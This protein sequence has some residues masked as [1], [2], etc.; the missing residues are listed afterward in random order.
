MEYIMSVFQFEDY[1]NVEYDDFCKGLIRGFNLCASLTKGPHPIIKKNL[2]T[3]PSFLIPKDVKD[4]FSIDN[5]KGFSSIDI[6]GAQP[7]DLS[8]INVKIGCYRLYQS[9]LTI[10]VDGKYVSKIEYFI[11]LDARSLLLK[12]KKRLNQKICD[13]YRNAQAAQDSAIFYALMRNSY[14]IKQILYNRDMLMTR[15]FYNGMATCSAKEIGF[16]F[17]GYRCEFDY[18]TL[19][20]STTLTFSF[21]KM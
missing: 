15:V 2:F 14:D 12:N 19:S 5:T 11:K 8:C 17:A 20:E 18:S 10:Y 9:N 16:D 4:L 1:N 3:K 6:V 13:Y 7:Q 21:N